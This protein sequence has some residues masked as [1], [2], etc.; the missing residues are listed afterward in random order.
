MDQIHRD[1]IVV[2]VHD[3]RPIGPE[4]PRMLAGGGVDVVVDEVQRVPALLTVVHDLIESDRTRRFVL[5]G[6]SARKLKRSGVDLMVGR[7]LPCSLHP[8]PLLADPG[9]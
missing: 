3:H 9:R 5:T 8:S 6:S 2:V 4:V 1:S 7:A